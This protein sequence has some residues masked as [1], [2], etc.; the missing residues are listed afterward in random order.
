M[1]LLASPDVGIRRL[2]L[3]ETG[4]QVTRSLVEFIAV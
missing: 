4:R 3:L 2:A 1:A